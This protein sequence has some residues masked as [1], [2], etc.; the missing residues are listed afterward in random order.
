SLGEI[1][2]GKKRD[3]HEVALSTQIPGLWVTPSDKDLS[4]TETVMGGRIGKE[5]MLRSALKCARTHYDVILVDC[6]PNLGTLT[7]NALVAADQVLIPCDMS[8]LALE[9]VDDIYDTLETLDENLGHELSVLGILR[10]R[11][12]RRNQRVNTRIE[13]ALSTR[14]TRDLLETTIPVNTR[15]AQ[16]QDEGTPALRY[17]RSCA[18]SVSYQ[19]L[20]EELLPKLGY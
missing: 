17:D 5:M 4:N 15:L 1:L 8:I 2:L 10:T 18:G 14:Y 20:A 13:S 19:A 9:G 16:A 6:P 7:V 12:D 3:V 11:V